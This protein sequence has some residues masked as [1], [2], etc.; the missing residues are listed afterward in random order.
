VTLRTVASWSL[1]GRTL[2]VTWSL[3]LALTVMLSSRM[4][5]NRVLGVMMPLPDSQGKVPLLDSQGRVPSLPH[6]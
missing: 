6:S 2:T 5:G 3:L 1:L 4:M